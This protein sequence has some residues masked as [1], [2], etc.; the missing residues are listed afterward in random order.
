MPSSRPTS[1]NPSRPLSWVQPSR[2]TSMALSVRTRRQSTSRPN[3]VALDDIERIHSYHLDDASIY[4]SGDLELEPPSPRRSRDVPR[5]TIDV[6]SA[7]TDSSDDK[8]DKEIDHNGGSTMEPIKSH[9]KSQQPRLSQHLGEKKE[10]VVAKEPEPEKDPDLV[11]WDGPDDPANP[12]NWTFKRKWAATAMVSMF[13]VMSPISSSMVAPSL[14]A[15]GETLGIHRE[16]E[17][18][19]SLSIFVLAYAF[20]PLALVSCLCLNSVFKIFIYIKS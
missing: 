16:I 19:L 20:G 5:Y 17:L 4:N 8:E 1:W 6:E 18:S 12:K 2:P 3:S 7:S 9:R 11:T 15:I 14:P 13:T 10:E